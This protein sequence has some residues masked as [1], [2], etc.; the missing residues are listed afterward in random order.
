VIKLDYPEIA[1]YVSLIVFVAYALLEMKRTGATI[2]V[3]K[4]YTLID[5]VATR[6]KIVTKR[7]P[8]PVGFTKLSQDDIFMKLLSLGY[9]W[10]YLAY[11]DEGEF[12]S[13]RRL[14]NERQVHVR[15]FRDGQIT[16]HDEVNYEFDP[17]RH[18]RDPPVIPAPEAVREV[19]EALEGTA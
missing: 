10:D 11:H 15:A 13:M 8:F 14:Y 3:L 6:L 16:M 1:G 5:I 9:Q 2:F 7:Q 4:V 19:L 18:L 17:I 12:I